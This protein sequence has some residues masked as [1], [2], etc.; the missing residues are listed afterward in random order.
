MENNLKLVMNS[1]ILEFWDNILILQKN[2]WE[3]LERYKRDDTNVAILVKKYDDVITLKSVHSDLEF[4]LNLKGGDFLKYL[5]DDT[6]KIGCINECV[7]RFLN[8]KLRDT[9]VF[10]YKKIRIYVND[11]YEFELYFYYEK[12]NFL[13]TTKI[14]DELIT[15]DMTIENIVNK[16][17]I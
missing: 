17:L 14:I 8:D 3:V 15:W 7:T 10:G 5:D 6:K 1:D 2:G 16:Y 11:N 9:V 13:S 12:K 4:E